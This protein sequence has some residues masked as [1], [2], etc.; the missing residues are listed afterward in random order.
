M[1]QV[2]NT[3]AIIILQYINVSNQH[4]GCLKLVQYANYISIN[5]KI[6]KKNK[7]GKKMMPTC[8][9]NQKC[10]QRNVKRKEKNK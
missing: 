5:F 4:I 9:K 3:M 8:Y 6:E 7:I 2:F 1:M 10:I